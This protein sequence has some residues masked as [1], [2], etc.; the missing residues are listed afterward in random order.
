MNDIVDQVMASGFDGH[1]I[2]V[3]NPVDVLSYYVYKRSG[4][5]KA[6]VI[7]TGTSIETARL[8][9]IIGERMRVD[10]EVS[11]PLLWESTAIRKW[12]HGLMF[13]LAEKVLMISLKI[14]LIAL[15]K[16]IK[17]NC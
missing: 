8:K 10:Q 9:Q 11:K 12:F 4:L 6:Q 5:S 2:I 16:L 1:I 15:E 3:S 14:M 17:I 13:V 7:G